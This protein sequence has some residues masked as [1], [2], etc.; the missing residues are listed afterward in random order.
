[1][2]KPRYSFFL[3]AE[4]HAFIKR[5]V[6]AQRM[7]FTDDGRILLA[8]AFL[9]LLVSSPGIRISTFLL[10]VFLAAWFLVSLAGAYLA[11]PRVSVRRILPGPGRAGGVLVYRV[12]VENRGRRPLE[13]FCLSEGALP[14]GLYDAPNHPAY[15]NTVP[16]LAPGGRAVLT[17]TIRCKYRRVYLLPRLW[18]ATSYPSGI[19][20]WP[21]AVGRRER[22]LVY[23]DFVEQ[24]RLSPVRRRVFQPGGALAG[25][26]AGE[27]G[28]FFAT[29][30]YRRGDRFR[31]IHWPSSARTGRLVVKEY[32]DEYFTRMGIFLD[33]EARGRRGEAGLEARVSFAAGLAAAARRTD[34]TDLFAAGG[35]LHHLRAGF[36]LA[37]WEAL[38]E[39]LACVEPGGPF[40]PERY[41]PLL[42]PHL[43]RLS[44]LAVILADWDVSRARF[45]R[46][47]EAHG[48][49]P[50]VF[51]VRDGEPNL[52]PDR[53]WVRVGLDEARKGAG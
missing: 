32:V 10:P 18:A 20:R 27:G 41:L 22:C 52:K 13:G 21:V 12:V 30:E 7:W 34:I 24:D 31:D 1:M 11:R 49:V 25:G 15:R 14:Y 17:L 43:P 51:V 5:A 6:V 47:V 33:T 28:E 44:R 48:G 37:R 16:S 8:A 35:V 38:L 36:R 53:P 39:L 19:V 3:P 40:A 26:H 9:G 2:R 4:D 50:E 45:C 29:R 46:E 23:P 42:V